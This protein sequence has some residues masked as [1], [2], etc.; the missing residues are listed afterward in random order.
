M[1]PLINNKYTCYDTNKYT[2]SPWS[3]PSCLCWEK[4][5][6]DTK[7]P[8]PWHRSLCFDVCLLWGCC[9]KVAGPSTSLWSWIWQ[10]SQKPGQTAPESSKSL[11]PVICGIRWCRKGANPCGTLWGLLSIRNPSHLNHPDSH[12]LDCTYIGQK[13]LI[14]YPNDKGN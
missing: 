1:D 10:P 7:S 9:M 2:W 14:N 13:F 11:F 4:L 6:L 5:S 3:L 12:R 8:L